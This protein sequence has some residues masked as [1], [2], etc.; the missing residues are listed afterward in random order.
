MKYSQCAKYTAT[1]SVSFSLPLK[2]VP[3]RCKLHWGG[4]APHPWRQPKSR[5]LLVEELKKTD[6]RIVR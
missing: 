1:W 2:K 3:L 5:V 6:E 4:T